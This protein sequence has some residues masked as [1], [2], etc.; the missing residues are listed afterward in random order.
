[1]GV[2]LTPCAVDDVVS[3][4]SSGPSTEIGENQLFGRSERG[5]EDEGE[6]PLRL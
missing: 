3:V 6:G 2:I 1:M 4:R 5:S